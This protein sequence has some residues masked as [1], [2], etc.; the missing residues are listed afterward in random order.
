[1]ERPELHTV[2]NKRGISEV[3]ALHSRELNEFKLLFHIFYTVKCGLKLLEFI[4]LPCFTLEMVS[5]GFMKNTL[6][7]LCELLPLTPSL[8]KGQDY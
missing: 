3:N 4:F 7:G 8:I 2:T 6:E 5:F 1:M